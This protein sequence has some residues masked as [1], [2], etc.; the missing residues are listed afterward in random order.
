M[1]P[2]AGFDGVCTNEHHQNA[3]GY[4][5]SPNLMGCVL[6]KLTQ[7]HRRRDRPDGRDSSHA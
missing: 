6:A 2:E 4:M 7:R 3:Y 5:P 1:R